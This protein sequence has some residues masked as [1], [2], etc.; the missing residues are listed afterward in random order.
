MR[1]YEYICM[2]L[3]DIPR[4]IIAKYELESL[5]TSG[6]AYIA[7]RKGMSGLK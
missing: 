7:I 3:V 2:A 4:E 5:S 6:W 1:R